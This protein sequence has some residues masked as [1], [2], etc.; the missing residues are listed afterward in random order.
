MN[1]LSC[2]YAEKNNDIIRYWVNST[3]LTVENYKQLILECIQDE[4][5]SQAE[6]Y[7]DYTINYINN[8]L[9]TNK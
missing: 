4:D 6:E 7:I 5:I 1:K 2:E 9:N 3:D 8:I